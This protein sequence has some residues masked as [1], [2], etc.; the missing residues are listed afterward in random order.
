M[1]NPHDR[2]AYGYPGGCECMKCGVIF[3]GAE[4]HEFCGVCIEIVAA[5]IAAAQG[6][7]PGV[8]EEQT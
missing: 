8:Q 4:H 5:E 7:R 2:P 3:V 6:L 1:K